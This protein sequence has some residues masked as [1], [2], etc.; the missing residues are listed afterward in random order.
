MKILIV[1]CLAVGLM[2]GAS[3]AQKSP[4]Q[5]FFDEVAQMTMEE[6]LA[7][8]DEL[9]AARRHEH[10]RRYYSFLADSFPNDPIGREAAL[11]VA[12]SFFRARDVESL[13]EAQLR[14]R[15]FSNRFPNDPRR[16]YALLMY[17]KCS[18]QQRRGPMRDLTQARE[19]LTSFLQLI[20]LYP[21]SE[22]AETARQ[23]LAEVREDL[24]RHELAIARFNM[25]L[26]AWRGAQ[27]RLE[28]LA[29][30][31][32]ETEAARSGSELREEVDRKVQELEEA[33]AAAEATA[34]AGAVQPPG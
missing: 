10:A 2:A 34:E 26:G 11:R 27:Q 6:V 32:P 30:N 1:L 23:M 22:H 29:R 24:G 16:P 5:V 18:F 28:Y 15:D 20:E 9:A 19:A 21:D 31:F 8:G 33:R 17:G 13:T 14:Y 3:C 7:K 12:D 4:D 25:R